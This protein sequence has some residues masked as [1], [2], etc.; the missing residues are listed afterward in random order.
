MR[1]SDTG[2]QAEKT[3]KL[4]QGILYLLVALEQKNRIPLFSSGDRGASRNSNR[5]ND[6]CCEMRLPVKLNILPGL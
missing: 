3:R 1:F 4:T 2:L 6:Y 5:T